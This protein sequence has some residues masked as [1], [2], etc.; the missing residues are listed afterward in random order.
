MAF[1]ASS[2]MRGNP[3][4]PP[5]LLVAAWTTSSSSR[6]LVLAAGCRGT[7]E[8]FSINLHQPSMPAVIQGPRLKYASPVEE[9]NRGTARHDSY[10]TGTTLHRRLYGS[11]A[12]PAVC[13]PP[14]L[15]ALSSWPSTTP[16]SLVPPLQR[17][18]WSHLGKSRIFTHNYT[19]F[20]RGKHPPVAAYTSHPEKQDVINTCVVDALGD[21]TKAHVRITLLFLRV[22]DSIDKRTKI[23]YYAY[24][25]SKF[26]PNPKADGSYPVHHR[27]LHSERGSREEHAVRGFH[28]FAVP[29]KRSMMVAL[30]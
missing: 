20:L 5:G 25:T 13:P 1:V 14:S 16:S 15:S 7:M 2:Q 6:Q 28:T 17:S 21:T 30:A 18:D 22:V 9:W 3:E 8:S 29:T 11:I 12:T 10:A 24:S 4:T 26:K 23:A 19:R 27:L